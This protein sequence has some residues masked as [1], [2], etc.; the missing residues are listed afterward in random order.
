[1]S[2]A[3]TESFQPGPPRH[4][5]WWVQ[6][7][8]FTRKELRET[9]R[10][11]RT[12]VTLLAMPLL[13]Y[14]MLGLVF[15]LVAL[16][17]R[18][19]A[20]RVEYRIAVATEREAEW[21]QEA[22]AVA[23]RN[24]PPAAAAAS[25]A[26][27]SPP[28]FLFMQ[29]VGPQADGLGAAV[30][31]AN[32]ELGARIVFP[33]ALEERPDR[34]DQAAFDARPG[35]RVE[36]VFCPESPASRE[37]RQIVEQRLLRLNL[38]LLAQ[39]LSGRGRSVRLPIE[40]DLSAVKSTNRSTGLLGLLPLILLLMTVTGGVYPAIDLTAGE[41]ERDTLETLFALPVSR[42][43]LLL[44]KYVAVLAVTLLTGCMNLLAM[45]ATVYALQLEV[46]LFGGAGLT[47]V[48]VAKLIV[49]LV[50]FGM[51]YSAVLLALT[52]AARSFKEAQAYLIPWMLL[53][54]AP[55]LVIL[56]PGWRLEGLP[57]VLPLINMLLLAR[58]LIEGTAAAL[59]AW[60][61]VVS[62]CLYTAGV[63]AVAS[64]WF[65]A[66]AVAV[67]SRGGWKDWL[68]RA[69]EPAD[70][71][72][73]SAAL[74]TL[75]ALFPLHFFASSALARLFDG[76]PAS[77]LAVAGGLTAALFGALPAAVAWWNRVPLTD[78]WRLRAPPAVVWLA[79]LVLGFGAWPWVY[80]LVLFVQQLGIHALDEEKKAAVEKLLEGWKTVPLA[81]IIVTLGVTPGICEELFFRGVLYGGVRREFGGWTAVVVT[82]LAFGLFHIVL[83]GGAAPERLVPSTILGLWLGWIRLRSGST[84][85]GIVLHVCHNSTLLAMTHYRAELANLPLAAAESTHLPPWWLGGSA[86]AIVVGLATVAIGT[87]RPV[88]E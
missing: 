70:A 1:M 19:S 39:A 57:A 83:A 46:Q 77:R 15:R 7:A 85:P 10:D 67:G 82:G 8:V 75:A 2:D 32:A 43:R 56:M 23:F 42:V 59:P 35:L 47:V 62:T 27:S 6:Q 63:L 28:K 68:R 78:A 74:V 52:S 5:S 61:A 34:E 36:L 25:E 64:Q 86:V 55:G 9:L 84:L 4:L 37:A 13:L 71:P 88:A 12:I 45:A 81:L 22:L 53:S 79:A 80:E 69:R 14:P 51:F 33:P 20:P 38:S 72:S 16:Q 31:E 26:D 24:E 73:L 41:R 18:S 11:R 44:A 49:V 21:L 48:L 54:L 60:G 29:S 76:S 17:D 40:T 3:S 58:E 50:V 30:A 66:D 87:R 65:G